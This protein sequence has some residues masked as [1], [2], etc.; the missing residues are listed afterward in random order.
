MMNQCKS[1]MGVTGPGHPTASHSQGFT[2][3]ELLVVIA[4]IAILAAMILPALASA[5]EKAWRVI[6]MNNEKQLYIGLHMYC[7]DNKDFLP[8]ITKVGAWAWDI[9][10]TATAGMMQSGCTKKTFFCPSTSPKF[11]DQQNWA[12]PGP[13]LWDYGG[14][15]FNIVGYEFA[16]WG[17]SYFDPQFQNRKLLPEE[18]TNSVPPITT[19]MDDVASRVV[20][21][22]VQISTGN[23]LPAS[24]TDNFIDVQGG[25]FLHHIS[26]HVKK[27]MP[28]GGNQTFKDGHTQWVKF[29]A[30]GNFAS[31]NVTQVRTGINNPY[32]WY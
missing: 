4:I 5:K 25:Y 14:N 32:F 19:F 2:L 8:Y 3:I 26:A 21:A 10:S 24:P 23:T 7:D 27:Q 16:F 30:S 18:H 22:D 9:P 1:K 28:V 17:A 6:C 15:G 29:Q 13:T 20:F 31:Q 12:G 11:T